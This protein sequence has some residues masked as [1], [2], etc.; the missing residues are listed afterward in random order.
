M[1]ADLAQRSLA[2]IKRA[3]EGAGEPVVYGAVSGFPAVGP[4]T[5]LPR[6]AY[7]PPASARVQSRRGG[8]LRLPD[9]VVRRGAI[10]AVFDVLH[11]EPAYPE[12]W[13]G[14]QSVEVLEAGN[15]DGVGEL[16]RYS[17]RSVLRTRWSSTRA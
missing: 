13:K 14:V 4:P 15:G 11:D 17:W 5:S 12:W 16:A 6:A 3:A 1:A 10:R 7:E 8:G 2:S 9:D